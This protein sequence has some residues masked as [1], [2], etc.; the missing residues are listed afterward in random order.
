MFKMIQCRCIDELE[1]SIRG[2]YR[3]Q[4]NASGSFIANVDCVSQYSE[5]ITGIP[6]I[7]SPS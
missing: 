6:V 2:D 3:D 5:N 4:T 7:G 1:K